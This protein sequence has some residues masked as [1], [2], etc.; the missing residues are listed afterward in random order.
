MAGKRKPRTNNTLPP[1]VDNPVERHLYGASKQIAE[2]LNAPIKGAAAVAKGAVRL[3]RG[4]AYQTFG[5]PNN[6]EPTFG[7]MRQQRLQEIAK[8][9]YS[10]LRTEY[11]R[12]GRMTKQAAKT[13]A[14]RTKKRE[15]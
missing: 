14:E 2:I 1:G 9:R 8:Q 13:K 7:S 6:A 3:A 4:G 15:R 11:E 12:Q 5:R 10:S